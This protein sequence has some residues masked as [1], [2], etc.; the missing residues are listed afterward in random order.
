MKTYIVVIREENRAHKMKYFNN[1]F[2][3]IV[4]NAEMQ[5]CISTFILLRNN[6]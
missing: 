4:Q 6:H 1:C 5:M 3:A 2:S